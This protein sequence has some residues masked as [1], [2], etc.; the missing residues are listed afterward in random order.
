MTTNA[1]QCDI[2]HLL[3]SLRGNRAVVEELAR[4]FLKV[5]PQQI[6]S[7]DA[8]LQDTDWGKLRRMAHDLRGSSA[9]FSA[10]TCR[11]LAGK[12]E[13][14]LRGQIGPELYEDCARFRE[15][16]A[17]LALELQSFLDEAKANRRD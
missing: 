8:A 17:G 4:T 10:A 1:K 2:D 5:Y 13:N 6:E 11:D 9:I 7:F 12:L 15:A 3:Q 16:Y 14:S